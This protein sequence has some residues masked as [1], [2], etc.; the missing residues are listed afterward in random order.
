MFGVDTI[1]AL[2]YSEVRNLEEA[3]EVFE[4][5][6]VNL[7]PVEGRRPKPVIVRVSKGQSPAVVCEIIV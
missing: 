7:I 4:D 1:P 3:V 5:Q 2:S 6:C